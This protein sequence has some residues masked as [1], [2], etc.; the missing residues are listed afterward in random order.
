LGEIHVRVLRVLFANA[1]MG[2]YKRHGRG[3]GPVFLKRRSG[4]P[5]LSSDT[6]KGDES[7]DGI[8]EEYVRAKS[9][10]NL[11]YLDNLTWPLFL[12]DYAVV[13]EDKL[14][15]DVEQEEDFIDPRSAAMISDDVKSSYRLGS[16][17][18]KKSSIPPYP[19][20]G[21]I[22]R[23]PVGPFGRR[24]PATGRFVCCPFHIH[25]ALKKARQGRPVS[26]NN[27]PLPKKRKRSKTPKS[28]KKAF[29]GSSSDY[30]NDSSDSD[31]DE[32]FTAKAKPK[33]ACKRGRPRKYMKVEPASNP[34]PS[35]KGSRVI[36][37]EHAPPLSSGVKLPMHVSKI[38]PPK[39]MAPA[40]SSNPHHRPPMAQFTSTISQHPPHPRP[41]PQSIVQ[42]TVKSAV[43]F[44][45]ILVPPIPP[46]PTDLNAMLVSKTTDETISRYFLEGDLFQNQA[47]EVDMNTAG[48]DESVKKRHLSINNQIEELSR[49]ALIKQLRSGIPYHHLSLEMK[50]TILEFLIDELLDVE[51]ISKELA[52][53]RLNTGQY[54]GVYGDLPTKSEL[55]E[56]V[57]ED[58]C[59]IC[60]LE[61][62]L[63]C[64]DGC[65]GSFHKQCQ[66]MFLTTK[67][68]EGKWLCTECRV[69][70]SSK[71]GPLR[72]E[73]R[74]MIGW[75][76]LK[77]LEASTPVIHNPHNISSSLSS[78]E[79][80]H[81]IVSQLNGTPNQLRDDQQGAQPQFLPYNQ[82]GAPPQFLLNNQQSVL[83]PQF[84][85]NNQHG[86]PP[87]FHNVLQ[88]PVRN[89][90]ANPDLS[91]K[92]PIDLE[93]LV[94]S[95]QVF[96][97]HRQ[98]HKRFDPSNPFSTGSTSDKSTES[99]PFSTDK[100]QIVP[101]KQSPPKPLTDDEVISL[102]QLLGPETCLKL[103]WR[104]LVF[105]PS[106]AFTNNVSGTSA[107]TEPLD[108]PIL[109]LVSQQK[110]AREI[111][112]K[113]P[114]TLNPLD[115]DNKYRKAPP[116]PQVN[117]QL[118]NFVITPIVPE[119]FTVAPKA[120]SQF[121]LDL[122][123]RLSHNSPL[124]NLVISMNFMDVNQSVR[125]QLVKVGRLLFDS[126]LLDP[127]WGTLDK[128]AAK[129]RRA[130]SFSKLSNL[131][132]ILADACC[133]RA[134][135]REWYQTKE[136]DNRNEIERI[137]H[138]NSYSTIINGW[139]ADGESKL[140]NWQ[141]CTKGRLSQ[142][143]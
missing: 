86:V 138:N 85:P 45:P 113:N 66:G 77:E 62:D 33:G 114:E 131:L 74:P 43:Q 12:E 36:D 41:M 79:R 103:P 92:I 10:D 30:S 130:K 123:G 120:A 133:W 52:L 73:S 118:G 140:R 24:N 107:P 37:V 139:N 63:I 25:A 14:L 142:I 61:G 111:M 26:A 38:L 15:N 8:V 91:K 110:E 93:F 7:G 31:S 48:T 97:R 22:D 5:L 117:E 60:G 75:F 90:P 70:D 50:L 84:V 83:S 46:Q 42:P 108:T 34:S 104:R 119:M 17:P 78:L 20:E 18:V 4:K 115:Y 40:S 54:T 32:D 13:M 44:Q 49:V 53:R 2:S 3:D 71:M 68:P 59:L 101:L 129:V 128:W 96:A 87:Q 109:D 56:L 135:Y 124:G 11:F 95:G 137:S 106:K 112:S 29:D 6:N 57:N 21:W 9:C 47:V 134:F 76:T 102:L 80:T 136:N 122:A 39:P 127:R 16:A 132:V 100:G 28:T 126:C 82:Q 81:H 1:G 121:G 89:L 125:D 35:I 69:A 65:P 105:N 94:T 64:C 51:D 67:L 72:S 58:E 141:R 27:A 98:S 88:Q 19:G 143:F 116:I 99:D 55:D 23:C